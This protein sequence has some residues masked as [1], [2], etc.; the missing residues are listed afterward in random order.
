MKI[1]ID[2]RRS[3][4]ADEEEANPVADNRYKTLLGTM[5]SVYVPKK[6]NTQNVNERVK[7]L[8][9]GNTAL[10]SFDGVEKERK[11]RHEIN[12]NMKLFEK[13]IRNYF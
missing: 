4:E 7:H 9:S 11:T 2:S 5:T 3:S 10:Q 12:S 6:S 8:I 13:L 1:P